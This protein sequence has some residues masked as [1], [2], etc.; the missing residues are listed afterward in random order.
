MTQTPSKKCSSSTTTCNRVIVIGPPNSGK[1]KLVHRI[2][3]MGNPHTR[4]AYVYNDAKD[5]TAP[6][7]FPTRL[8]PL[9]R[10]GGEGVG[11]E[12]FAFKSMSA[13]DFLNFKT[14]R[15]REA[16]ERE[17]HHGRALPSKEALERHMLINEKVSANDLTAAREEESV[18]HRSAASSVGLFQSLWAKL[19]G[20]DANGRQ[21]GAQRASGASAHPCALG[22]GRRSAAA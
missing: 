10:H 20:S 6:C 14:K 17:A 19:W 22:G 3:A 5:C 11:V 18:V 8:V 13:K 7:D 4:A 21:R 1:R 16:C 15:W 9:L 2:V 12:D